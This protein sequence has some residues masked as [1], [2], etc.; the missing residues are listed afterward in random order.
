MSDAVKRGVRTFFQAFIGTLIASG[1]LTGV[2]DSG[3]VDLSAFETAGVSAAAAGVVAVLSWIQ[4]ALEDNTGFP[5]V[6]KDSD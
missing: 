6:L 5:T 1:V 3:T 4:N 2:T